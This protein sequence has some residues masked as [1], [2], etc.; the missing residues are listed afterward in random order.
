MEQAMST[1]RMVCCVWAVAMWTNA[2]AAKI[3]V[4][5]DAK[6]ISSL[7]LDGEEMLRGPGGTPQ[8]WARPAATT[9][10]ATPVKGKPAQVDAAQ[11]QVSWEFPCGKLAAKYAVSGDRLDVTVTVSNTTP[12]QAIDE[13]RWQAMSL[14]APGQM[15]IGQPVHTWEAP[16]FVGADGPGLAVALCNELADRPLTLSIS[17]SVGA[18][19]LN[20]SAGGMR[21]LSHDVT[22][23][24]QIRPG[25]SDTYRLSVRLG[26]GGSSSM[27][28]AGDVMDAF[29]RAHPPTLK[30]PD[31]RPILRWFV[32][33]GLPREQAIEN[34]KNPDAVKPPAEVSPAMR[35]KADTIAASALIAAKHTNAQAMIFWDLEGSTFPHPTT[36]IGDPRLIR[37]LNPEMDLVSDELMKKL[38]DGGLKVGVTLRPTQVVFSEARGNTAVHSHSA[39]I[40]PLRQLIAKAEYCIK[41]WDCKVFYVDTNFFWKPYPPDNK[42]QSG[43]LPAEHWRKLN[44]KFPDVL[45]IPEFGTAQYHA[46]TAVYGEADMNNWQ[47]SAL[48]R[49]IYPDAFRV[50]VIEDADPVIH[51]DRF[52]KTVRHRDVLMTFG[53]GTGGNV[54]PARDIHAEAAL[55]D[56]G[57]PASVRG[58]S[59][60]KLLALLNDNDQAVRYYAAV[61][62]AGHPGDATAEALIALARSDDQPWVVRKA[63]LASLVSCKAPKI[64]PDLVKLA[65]DPSAKLYAFAWEALAACGDAATAPLL[66]AIDAAIPPGEGKPSLKLLCGAL[67]RL[68]DPGAVARL[69]AA[70]ERIPEKDKSARGE[71]ITALGAIGKVA[72]VGDLLK[73]FE[74]TTD[75][76]GP[77]A[78]ALCI[79][80]DARAIAV[81]KQAQSA[82]QKAGDKPMAE[83]L[84]YALRKAPTQ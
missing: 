67:R 65:G 17:R 37:V 53:N 36:Y 7:K 3:E 43:M 8:L 55:L 27:D 56:A 73:M 49:R 29:A 5:F 23:E 47:T 12:D 58:A 70:Y 59:A 25:A 10:P 6:G 19:G 72:V 80:G 52:V 4:G 15:R 48:V 39:D 81:V 18:L 35:K 22:T 11:Q 40:D 26:K 41:R 14:L 16:A 44:E 1:M 71:V 77:I 13:V 46:Y 24:R 28:L 54:L 64:V 83:R 63:A 31:R 32:G 33:G 69:R 21:I 38:R 57:E 30:W 34:L 74:A 78:D 45:F 68:D 50:I 9:Q 62:L 2:A 84:G 61:A 66:D 42:W 79:T 20:V 51:H 82:A 76:K 75:L 60:E